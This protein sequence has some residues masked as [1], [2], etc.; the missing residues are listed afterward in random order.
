MSQFLHRLGAP[1]TSSLFSKRASFIGII[2]VRL[3]DARITRRVKST[4]LTVRA[5]N[6]NGDMIA[7]ESRAPP[8][9]SLLKIWTR[10]EVEVLRGAP[11][12]GMSLVA[13]QAPPRKD[14]RRN[15]VQGREASHP[16]RLAWQ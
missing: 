9:W 1:V 2:G 12:I 8:D 13:I 14:G 6:A 10:K 11:R 5:E 16:H 3:H 15:P 4:S 7:A